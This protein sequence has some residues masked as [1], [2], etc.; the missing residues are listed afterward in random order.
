MRRYDLVSPIGWDEQSLER[1]YSEAGE[2]VDAGEALEALSVRDQR[3]RKLE[4]FVLKAGRSAKA[5]LDHPYTGAADR[6]I[7]AIE[8]GC[9][10][11]LGRKTFES[12]EDPRR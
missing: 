6:H 5:A 12:G 4:A 2:H 9:L 8:S 7:E 10:R 1:E 3:I 11:I